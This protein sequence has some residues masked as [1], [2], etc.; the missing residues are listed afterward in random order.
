MVSSSAAREETFP[1][2][3][4]SSPSE[5]ISF[6]IWTISSLASASVLI[7]GLAFRSWETQSFPSWPASSTPA[8]DAMARLQCCRRRFDRIG[9]DAL[10]RRLEP[11]L[12]GGQ[13]DARAQHDVVLALERRIRRART[14]RLDLGHAQDLARAGVATVDRDAAVV[15]GR[16]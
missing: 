10:G 8:R 5:N 13:R 14:T 16:G 7:G 6:V 3:A 1:P 15:A 9:L 11:R 4:V 2:V 12:A